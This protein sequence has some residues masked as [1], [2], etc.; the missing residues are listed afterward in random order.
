MTMRLRQY[1]RT[2]FGEARRT[3]GRHGYVAYFPARIPRAIE[4]GSTTITLLADAEAALGRLAG[5]GDLLPNPH[6]L[7]RPHVVR[8]AVF[9]TRIEG[10]RASIAD[11]FELEAGGDEPNPDVEEVLG[12]VEALTWGLEQSKLPL[13]IRLMREMHRRL[14]AGVRGR[15][16]MPGELRTSQNWIGAPG[17]TIETAEFVPPPPEEIAN[18]LGDWESFAHADTALP[19]LVRNALLHYQLE[20]IHPF[21]DGNGRIGRLLIV[22]MLVG[23]DRLPAPLLDV[24][25][26]FE[27]DRE[28]YYAA[29]RGVSESGDAATWID[30]FLRAIQTQATEAVARARRLFELREQYRQ[31]AASLPSRNAIRLVDLACEAPVLTARLVTERLDVTRPTAGSLLRQ[32]ESEG[33]LARARTG[34]R[35]QRRYVARE[36][37]A[38]LTD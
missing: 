38:A 24:S 7:I 12:Y 1:P 11:V 36:I 34:G 30:L 4:L 19:L 28:S 17:S 15:D 23:R 14:M 9:S 13:S 3:G 2:Q 18:L 10:T 27:R 8:E 22:F 6:L 5:I 32:L 16:R 21:L 25:S 20:T 26:Y 29:L 31:R 33:L 37:L 35:G